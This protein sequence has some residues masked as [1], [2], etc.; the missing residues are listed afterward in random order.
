MLD[1][2]NPWVGP[3]RRRLRTGGWRTRWGRFPSAPAIRVVDVDDPSSERSGP[4]LRRPIRNRVRSSPR[5]LRATVVIF[6]VVILRPNALDRHEPRRVRNRRAHGHEPRR[7]RSDENSFADLALHFGPLF[8]VVGHRG[9]QGCAVAGTA[10]DA[11]LDHLVGDGMHGHHP[12]SHTVGELLLVVGLDRLHGLDEFRAEPLR[13]LRRR[14][15]RLDAEVD[16][17]TDGE[18]ITAAC[19]LPTAQPNARH[20]AQGIHLCPPDRTCPAH[21]RTSLDRVAPWAPGA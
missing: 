21:R 4:Q 5:G 20:A 14:R 10:Q 16:I 15:S 17:I 11:L 18:R 6:I 2:A 9:V 12:P 8:A 3:R 13:E 19:P 7:P 1:E